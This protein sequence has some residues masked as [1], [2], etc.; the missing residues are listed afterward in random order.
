MGRR[1]WWILVLELSVIITAFAQAAEP[2]PE[3]YGFYAVDNGRLIELQES[4]SPPDVGSAVRFIVFQNNL[5]PQSRG[6]R[7][8][9]MRYLR[10]S[11]KPDSKPP[12]KNDDRWYQVNDTTRDI[13]LRAKPI[14]GQSQM[15]ML[16]PRQQLA[17]GAYAVVI[18]DN[19]VASIFVNK[20]T[21]M[22]DLEK[23]EDCV[24]HIY[25]AM[26][27]D[28]SWDKFDAIMAGKR[29]VVRCSQS[30]TPAERL[31]S[32]MTD[33]TRRPVTSPAASDLT[34]LAERCGATF[35]YPA[36][37]DLMPNE[38]GAVLA[39]IVAPAA[40][41]EP[42]EARTQIQVSCQPTSVTLDGLNVGTQGAVKKA[43]KDATI[44][45]STRTTLAGVDAYVFFVA[46]GE[47]GRARQKA[48]TVAVRESKALGVVLHAT[49]ETFEDAWDEYQRVLASYTVH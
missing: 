40:G 33:L 43:Y 21:V 25:E 6:M 41:D 32:L 17:S 37:W 24:D 35:S 26:G 13:E 14:A 27:E 34:Y 10:R 30:M 44:T 38:Q 11:I 16:V 48:F 9:R 2:L 3:F 1:V 20:A 31:S 8:S 39:V 23:S 7:V 12:T 15:M 28:F 42:L 47:L 46:G 36:G 49:S 29:Q 4:G 45:G 19:H 5:S 22:S 18:G